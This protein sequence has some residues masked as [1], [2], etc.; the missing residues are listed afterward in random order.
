MQVPVPQHR[1]TPLREN[2][3]KLYQPVTE[4]LQLDMRMNLKTKKVG[5]AAATGPCP[6]SLPCCFLRLP[7]RHPVAALSAGQCVQGQVAASAHLPSTNVPV[8]LAPQ[9]L[10]ICWQLTRGRPWQQYNRAPCW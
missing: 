4:H 7:P 1:L 5:P 6:C 9:P 10:R 2:W 8:S 3:L